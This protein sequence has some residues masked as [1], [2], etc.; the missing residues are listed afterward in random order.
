MTLPDY[1]ADVA[2][3]LRSKSAAIRRDFASH[4]P[5]AGDNREDLV[6]RFLIDHLP[7]RFGVSSGLIISHVGLF[8]KQ[9]DLVVVDHH[10]NAPLYG[11]SRTKLWPVEAV[12]GLIEVKTSLSPSNI[13]DAITKGRHFKT[14]PRQFCT[15]PQPPRIADSL[16]VIWAF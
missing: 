14:L 9:A 2:K 1:L 12:Y 7:K 3:E 10:N 8:S 15:G 4:R 5:S 11:S 16:F 6:E 13:A